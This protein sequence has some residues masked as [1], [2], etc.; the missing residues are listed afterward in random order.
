MND[1]NWEDRFEELA[2]K[3]TLVKEENWATATKEDI[4]SLLKEEIQKAEES[5][6]VEVRKELKEFANAVMNI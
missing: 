5:G 1:K 4:K 6:R 3:T 2:N